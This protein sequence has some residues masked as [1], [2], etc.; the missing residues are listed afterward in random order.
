MDFQKSHNQLLQEKELLYK[1]RREIEEMLLEAKRYIQNHEQKIQYNC[2][3]W[4]KTHDW[5]FFYESGPYGERYMIC[6][7]CGLENW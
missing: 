1:K 6:K 3:K 2:I 4:N 7:H 5:E